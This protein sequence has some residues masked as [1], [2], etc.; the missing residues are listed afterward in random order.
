MGHG[1]PERQHEPVVRDLHPRRMLNFPLHSDTGI[2][3]DPE[4]ILHFF[5]ESI[6]DPKS[7]VLETA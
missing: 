5:L 2:T 6:E 1:R 4:R 7:E 3:D